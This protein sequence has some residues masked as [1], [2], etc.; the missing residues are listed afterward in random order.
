MNQN[1]KQ[2][3]DENEIIDIDPASEYEPSVGEKDA[4]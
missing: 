3:D 1:S 4:C 2:Y